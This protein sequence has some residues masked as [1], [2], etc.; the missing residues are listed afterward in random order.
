MNESE[1]EGKTKAARKMNESSLQS[2]KE[3]SY[4]ARRGKTKDAFS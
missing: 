1:Q 3:K 2:L 4:C